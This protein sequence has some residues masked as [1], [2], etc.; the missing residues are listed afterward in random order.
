MSHR[1]QVARAAAIARA[2]S[3]LRKLQAAVPSDDWT[4]EDIEQA[5]AIWTAQMQDLRDPLPL[6][7]PARAVLRRRSSGALWAEAA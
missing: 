5:T 3:E 4:A 6:P 7:A 2:Q 1:H